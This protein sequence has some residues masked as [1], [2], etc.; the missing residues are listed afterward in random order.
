M[1]AALIVIV[2]GT[3]TYRFL[4]NTSGP[5]PTL[6]VI[7]ADEEGQL[8]KARMDSAGAGVLPDS[9]SDLAGLSRQ[10]ENNGAV[11]PAGADTFNDGF[12]ADGTNEF[13]STSQ[14]G[15]ASSASPTQLATGVAP[16][17]DD[18]SAISSLS[19]QSSYSDIRQGMGGYTL[20][21]G[22]SLKQETAIAL[23]STVTPLGWPSGVLTHDAG[24]VVRYRV[25][26]GHF[27]TAVLADST[28]SRYAS[29]L[30][31]GTWVLSVR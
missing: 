25:A 31:E 17:A 30:P 4:W 5:A 13:A 29:E 9:L 7:D 8:T 21:V 2:V 26:V 19:Q 24:D 1:A 14:R 16:I 11:G 28:R 22:S 10:D 27:Q 12:E 15:S 18:P 3:L 23:M 6:A 20:I